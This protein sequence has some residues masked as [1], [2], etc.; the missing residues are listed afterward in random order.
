VFPFEAD[1]MPLFAQ[2]PHRF[3]SYK[4]EEQEIREEIEREIDP[5]CSSAAWKQLW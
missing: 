4:S 5:A 2:A 1:L 3:R